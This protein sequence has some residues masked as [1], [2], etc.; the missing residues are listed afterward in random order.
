MTRSGHAKGAS[1]R[2]ASSASLVLEARRA[3]RSRSGFCGTH[4]A[5]CPGRQPGHVGRL[6]DLPHREP[7]LRRDVVHL[8]GSSRGRP[9][10]PALGEARLRHLDHDRGRLAE[11]DHG[12]CGVGA[13]DRP[14]APRRERALDAHVLVGLE[15]VEAVEAEPAA[16]EE[17]GERR[18]AHQLRVGH[19]GDVDEQERAGR[20]QP[21]VASRRRGRRRGGAGASRRRPGAAASRRRRPGPGRAQGWAPAGGARR[22]GARRGRSRAGG[23]RAGRRP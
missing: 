10:G 16:L 11:R 19:V 4:L 17:G 7:E 22:A 6:G 1:S 8:V 2:E 23:R 14:L 21:R 9:G 13:Q 3:P 12:L 5:A 18:L 20:G 15:L